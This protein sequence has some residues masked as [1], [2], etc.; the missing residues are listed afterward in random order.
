VKFCKRGDWKFQDNDGKI[1]LYLFP[2]RPIFASSGA[3][4][5]CLSETSGKNTFLCTIFSMCL[6]IALLPW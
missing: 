2:D 4:R 5:V 3:F 6:D 1:L